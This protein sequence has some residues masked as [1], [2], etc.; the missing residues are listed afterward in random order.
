M[1]LN[2][3]VAT[4]AFPRT[5]ATPEALRAADAALRTDLAAQVRRAVGDGTDKIR[6]AAASLER[7][8]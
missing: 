7:W 3:E 8:V 6:R 1:R 4:Q 2:F 5:A